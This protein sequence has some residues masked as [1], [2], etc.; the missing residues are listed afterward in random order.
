MNV[1]PATFHV[2]IYTGP[3]DSGSGR[4]SPPPIPWLSKKNIR[5][6]VKSVV[7]QL[8]VPVTRITVAILR[9]IRGKIGMNASIRPETDQL[10]QWGYWWLWIILC[11]TRFPD[12]SSAIPINFCWY[13]IGFQGRYTWQ[14]TKI[15]FRR[16]ILRISYTRKA[17]GTQITHCWLS[18]VVT[19]NNNC[20]G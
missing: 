10:R 6:R 19:K 15:Q 7:V 3:R 8:I 12:H 17:V 18:E 13:G 5:N 2:S 4:T 16:G 11:I 9:V 20:C 1:F 14:R